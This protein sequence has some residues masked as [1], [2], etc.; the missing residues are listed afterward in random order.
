MKEE[1]DFDLDDIILSSLEE[2][3]K[4]VIDKEE[5]KDKDKEKNK[6]TLGGI[7]N[8]KT[9]LIKDIIIYNEEKDRKV[10]KLYD[11]LTEEIIKNIIESEVKEKIVIY[12]QL[13]HI[14]MINLKISFQI[15]P[16]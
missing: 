10:N 7:E 16:S 8:N 9:V 3:I 15:I 13:N 4:N 11:D 12:C 14:N 5:D 1:N 2:D 6:K